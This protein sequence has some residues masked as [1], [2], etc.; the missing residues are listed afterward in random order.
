[1][2]QG[3]HNFRSIRAAFLDELKGLYDAEEINSILYILFEDIRGWPRTKLHTE[4]GTLLGSEYS[5]KFMDAL[6]RLSKGCP[7]QYITGKAWFNELQLMVNPSVLIPRP[8]T[9]E[10]AMLI[11]KTTAP[12]LK[13]GFSAL[14]IGTGSGCLAIYLRKHLPLVYMRGTDI[15]EDALEVSRSNASACGLEIDFLLSD[16]LLE[17]NAPV[18]KKFNLVVSNPPY[19]TLKEKSAMRSNV[20]DYEPHEALFVPDDDP[21]RFYRGIAAYAGNCLEEEGML[22]L[23]INEAYGKELRK[24]LDAS[25]FS[26]ICLLQDFHGRDRFMKAVFRSR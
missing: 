18:N 15:L 23:E 19:V 25:G 14:D 13:D 10:L 21:M 2:N 22:W 1:M 4:P 11:V 8:E 5:V 17:C 7:V 3:D 20:L 12:L 16:I 26:D 9:A 24:L 6:E